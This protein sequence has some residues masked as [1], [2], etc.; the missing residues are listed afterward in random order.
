MNWGDLV[1]VL[2]VDNMPEDIYV[3]WLKLWFCWFGKVVD[4]FIL[5]PARKGRGS[6]FCFLH[7]REKRITLKAIQG[8]VVA[9]CKL[10][11]TGSVC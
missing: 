11:V 10:E 4:N 5:V 9:F 1:L 7:L 3:E 2:F 8:L 6:C